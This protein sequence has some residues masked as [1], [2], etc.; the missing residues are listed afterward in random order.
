MAAVYQADEAGETPAI[1]ALRLAYQ[2]I[3]EPL[4]NMSCNVASLRASPAKTKKV[5]DFA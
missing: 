5:S 1:P 4:M 3:A 2:P